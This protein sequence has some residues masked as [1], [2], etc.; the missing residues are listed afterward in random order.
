MSRERRVHCRCLQSTVDTLIS[1]SQDQ[2]ESP[3]GKATSTMLDHIRDMENIHWKH[4]KD[5]QGVVHLCTRVHI[6]MDF[7]RG[8]EYFSIWNINPFRQFH[9]PRRQQPL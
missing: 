4:Q 3:R 5:R 6:C 9:K 2:V 7:Q 1:K 8:L